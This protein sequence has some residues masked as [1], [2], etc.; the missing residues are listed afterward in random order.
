MH[1]AVFRKT[2]DLSVLD[3]GYRFE[4]KLNISKSTPVGFHSIYCPASVN[5]KQIENALSHDGNANSL[6]FLNR[7]LKFPCA[8]DGFKTVDSSDKSFY[9]RDCLMPNVVDK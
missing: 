8:F 9:R 7:T 3:R 6:L 4:Y 2:N 1:Y 5:G